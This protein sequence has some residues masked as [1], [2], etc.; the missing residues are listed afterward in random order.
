LFSNF[1][2]IQD[3][4]IVTYYV[5]TWSVTQSES[6]SIFHSFRHF[7]PQLSTAFDVFCLFQHF[8]MFISYLSIL[9][10]YFWMTFLCSVYVFDFPS[11]QTCSRWNIHLVNISN[12]FLLYLQSKYWLW[13]SLVSFSVWSVFQH[14]TLYAQGHNTL[15]EANPFCFSSSETLSMCSDLLPLFFL[16]FFQNPNLI[17]NN[18]E[19]FWAPNCSDH[20][21][22]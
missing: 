21:T 6:L 13:F 19:T 9:Q 10:L 3:Q 12:Y 5:I 16:H 15:V 8:S 22:K 20:V 18:S 7:F 14:R 11:L 17:Y 4:V 2:P 1:T